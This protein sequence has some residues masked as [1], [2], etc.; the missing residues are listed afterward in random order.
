MLKEHIH[1]NF[2][3]NEKYTK[4]YPAC[5]IAQKSNMEERIFDYMAW[6]IECRFTK[7]SLLQSYF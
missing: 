6:H 3:G 4:T 7:N 1:V 5:K 2:P